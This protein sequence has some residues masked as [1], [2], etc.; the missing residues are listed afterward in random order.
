MS[1][2][3]MWD[4]FTLPK[5]HILLAKTNVKETYHDPFIYCHQYNHLF[6]VTKM[7]NLL[8]CITRVKQKK[9]LDIYNSYLHESRLYPFVPY[10]II[11]M[12]NLLSCTRLCSAL[13]LLCFHQYTRS[14]TST[15]QSIQPVNV[16]TWIS[17]SNLTIFSLIFA[18]KSA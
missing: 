1:F 5:T 12:I 6:Q 4:A 9:F 15:G 18:T 16:S 7:I 11:K 2:T 17:L 13:T 14:D 3:Y 10:Q 8:S